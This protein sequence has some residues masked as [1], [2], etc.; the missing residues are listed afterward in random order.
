MDRL[1]AVHLF[2][3]YIYDCRAD[4]RFDASETL[5]Y[6]WKDE[7]AGPEAFAALGRD[8]AA[9]AATRRSAVVINLADRVRQRCP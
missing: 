7:A 9:I 8:R 3:S 5:C 2:V 1:E 4:G 6:A